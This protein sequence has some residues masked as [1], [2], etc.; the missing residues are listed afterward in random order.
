MKQVLCT[1][2]NAST[3]ISGFEFHQVAEGMLSDP[4]DDDDA[5]RL[6][7]I[8]GF[9]EYHAPAPA[10]APTP[11]PVASVAPVA[12]PVAAPV[13]PPTP[14]EGQPQ[15]EQTGADGDAEKSKLDLLRAEATA[16]GISVHHN[17]KETRLQA[18]IDEAKAAAKKT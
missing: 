1:I 5:E 13:A 4:M 7:R 9:T 6:M 11:A 15:G 3:N 12:P 14:A 8:E 10:Q 18:E 16:L 2:P 17:W